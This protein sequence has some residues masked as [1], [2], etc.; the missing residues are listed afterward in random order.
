MKFLSII[1]P[2]LLVLSGPSIA[3]PTPNPD[4]TTLSNVTVVDELLAT[5][6]SASSAGLCTGTPGQIITNP[7]SGQCYTHGSGTP[8]LFRRALWSGT[9]S[10]ITFYTT[11]NCSGTPSS[12]ATTSA[13]WGSCVGVGLVDSILQDGKALPE[14][15]ISLTLIKTLLRGGESLAACRWILDQV[16]SFKITANDPRDLVAT[17]LFPRPQLESRASSQSTEV[18]IA[19]G[20]VRTA[21]FKAEPFFSLKALMRSSADSEVTPSGVTLAC[22]KF[23]AWLLGELSIPANWGIDFQ[24]PELFSRAVAAEYEHTAEALKK[25]KL[26]FACAVRL[27]HVLRDLCSVVQ[28]PED[29]LLL[30]DRNFYSIRSIA[31]TPLNVFRAALLEPSKLQEN[32]H[33]KDD[34]SWIRKIYDSARKIHHG[35]EHM[36]LGTIESLEADVASVQTVENTSPDLPEPNT[37]VEGGLH[38]RETLTDLFLMKGA[39]CEVC[40]HR[41]N[42]PAYFADMMSLL[43]QDRTGVEDGKT[44]LDVLCKRRPDV[45][46]LQLTCANTRTKISHI[47]L[48]NEVLES[49]IR[50]QADKDSRP[51][52]EAASW[53]PSIPTD[54]EAIVC[55]GDAEAVPAYA[56]GNTDEFVY[57]ELISQ[58]LYPFSVF[59]FNKSRYEALQIL[60]LLELSSLQLVETLRDADVLLRKGGVPGSCWQEDSSVKEQVTAGLAEVFARQSAAESLGMTQEDF[61]AITGETYITGWFADLVQGLSKTGL[62]VQSVVGWSAARLWGYSDSMSMLDATNGTGLSYVRQLMSRSE[63]SFQDVVELVKTQT[64]SQDLV[65]VHKDGSIEIKSSIEDLRLLASGLKPL[66]EDL[67]WRLQAFIRLRSKLGWSIKELDAAICCLRNLEPPERKPRASDSFAIT[68]FVI[69]SLAAIVKLATRC[70]LESAALLPLWGPMDS[71]GDKSFLYTKFLTPA[72]RMLTPVFHQSKDHDQKPLQHDGAYLTIDE[73]AMG[74]CAALRWPLHQFPMLRKAAGLGEGTALLTLDSLSTLYRH[75]MICQMLSIAPSDCS[76]FFKLLFDGTKGFDNPETT[77]AVFELCTKLFNG[78][79]TLDSLCSVLE[80]TGNGQVGDICQVLDLTPEEILSLS[81]SKIIELDLAALTLFQLALLQK[82][83]ELRESCAQARRASHAGNQSD[84]VSLF[85]WLSQTIAADIPEAATRISAATGWDRQRVEEILRFKYDDNSLEDQKAMMTSLKSFDAMLGL[86]AI[87]AIDA[88]LQRAG[89]FEALPAINTLVAFAQPPFTLNGESTTYLDASRCL[90]RGLTPSQASAIDTH[91]MTKQRDVLVAFLLQQDD[92]VK[93][94]I[95]DADGLMGY[96]LVDTHT[97]SQL[98]MSRI[99]HAISTMKVFTQ[100]CF[101]GLESEVARE[102]IVDEE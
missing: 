66:T 99:E 71:F 25:L 14:E 94:G 77:L 38:A 18:T 81:F 30:C 50:Y 21:F 63:I 8:Q 55:H 58:Q 26:D 70:G 75:A 40:G 47:G 45:L 98:P 24:D 46:S 22:A 96:L 78:G 67:C 89:N 4:Y 84:L 53:Q 90:R 36:Y 85:Q 100:R 33:S 37:T 6:V 13:R 52:I 42:L 17:V 74:I 49:Y 87:M 60:P 97:G 41:N 83:I 20:K 39:V 65:I 19:L 76:R 69:K 59:P 56:T 31:T 92:I 16:A 57:T 73:T 72:M 9:T 29:L 64:F 80:T 82:Y 95:K 91:M 2:I 101:L 10:T 11:P 44:T 102:D 3:S 86:Q 68:P 62:K 35:D 43:K 48:V 32:S 61:A 93:Q 34:N 28:E 54:E 7:T 23:A 88:H 79:W 27:V 51:R 5:W 1:T 15:I 12:T